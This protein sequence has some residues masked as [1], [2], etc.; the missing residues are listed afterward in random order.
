MKKPDQTPTACPICREPI[1]CADGKIPRH[2][3]RMGVGIWPCEAASA[4]V[5]FRRIW[6]K[7][8]SK[9]KKSK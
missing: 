7:E 8:V 3:R 5:G 2:G 1:V 9:E 6:A 4:G